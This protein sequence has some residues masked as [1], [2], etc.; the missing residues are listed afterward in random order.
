MP[1]CRMKCSRFFD[2]SPLA[3]A[4]HNLQETSL[5]LDT[6]AEALQKLEVLLL[7]SSIGW[8]APAEDVQRA[9]WSKVTPSLPPPVA[10]PL[11][12]PCKL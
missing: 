6:D 1:I 12:L 10:L 9:L 2:W 5:L 11:H 8:V 3:L 7:Q 4:G